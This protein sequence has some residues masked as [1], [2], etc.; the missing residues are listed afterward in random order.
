M[1]TWRKSTRLC[2]IGRAYTRAFIILGKTN[3]V[4]SINRRITQKKILCST[5]LIAWNSLIWKQGKWKRVKKTCVKC[6][7][8]IKIINLRITG[9][10]EEQEREKCAGTF[11]RDIMIENFQNWGRGLDIWI[12]EFYGL[13]PDINPKCLSK[14]HYNK[15][16]KLKTGTSL[17]IQQL[18]CRSPNAGSL[19]FIPGQGTRPHMLQLKI[20]H[21]TT[22]T[23]C[24]QINI[25]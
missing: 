6:H 3:T 23:P 7:I 16:L 19:D 20:L 8:F 4:E 14:I 11:F 22:K 13:P 10:P 5:R 24:N 17:V 18:R 9:V 21:A 1:S 25:F 2:R 12:H 15:A